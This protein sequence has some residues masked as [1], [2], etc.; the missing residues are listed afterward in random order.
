M[1]D[2][3]ARPSEKPPLPV[4]S[5]TMSQET[6][7]TGRIKPLYRITQIIW[8]VVGLIE[9]LLLLRLLL[10][11]LGAN[12]LAGFSQFIYG[13]T[14]IFASPFLLVFGASKVQG[15]IFEWSTLLAML[16]YLLVGWLIVK[17][18]VMSRPVSTK[19]AERKLPDQEK[20]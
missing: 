1:A 6:L 19:E 11:G 8:Y 9:V 20:V 15:A 12:P 16:V 13:L 2:E 10:K 18:V 7:A 4:V 3:Q 5:G 14:W 17:A